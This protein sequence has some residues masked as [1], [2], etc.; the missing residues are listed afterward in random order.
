MKTLLVADGTY[1]VSTSRIDFIAGTVINLLA[2][3]GSLETAV[4]S[5]KSAQ[6]TA[7]DDRATAETALRDALRSLIGILTDLLDPN[8][9]LWDDFGLNRPG[10]TVT[11]G[12][13]AAPTLLKT[14]PTTVSAT[15]PPV[16][17][18]T[19]YR[20]KMKIVGVDPE[21]RFAG[22]TSDPN[23]ALT[24]LP[25]TGTLEVLCE[26]ANEAGPGVASEVATLVLG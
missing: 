7:G 25:A 11:P 16:A 4:A 15:V 12:Q 19:Y 8:S 22:R 20:W 24:A 1:E 6:K 14:G 17:L 23:I 21:F 3:L 10:A 26:A 9:P 2:I 5:A 13:P 18:A